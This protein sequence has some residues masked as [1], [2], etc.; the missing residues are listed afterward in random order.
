MGGVI[1]GAVRLA[2]RLRLLC[3]AASLSLLV[4]CGPRLTG[5]Y[6]ADYH[7]LMSR[8]VDAAG[9][10]MNPLLQ[11]LPENTRRSLEQQ[12]KAM[13]DQ[14]ASQL[15]QSMPTRLVFS[16][17]KVVC[18][19]SGMEVT[20]RY[21]VEAD[22]VLIGPVGGPVSYRLTK[23]S[24]GTLAFNGIVFRPIAGT[25]SVDSTA[26]V[27]AWVGGILLLGGSTFACVW[28][29][30]RRTALAATTS[31]PSVRTTNFERSALE[32]LAAGSSVPPSRKGD[33]KIA[34]GS[35]VQSTS[36][37][38]QD[39]SR[40]MPPETEQEQDD[41]VHAP[42]DAVWGYWQRNGGVIGVL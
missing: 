3:F 36:P 29:L 2:G 31:A 25:G 20:S 42:R 12:Q 13:V 16:G 26:T 37:V 22:S 27:A 19:V 6:E 9:Q 28:F 41:P 10:A 5:V 32:R 30:R 14:T 1:T 38:V 18:S 4:G 24:N 15:A 17:R 33:Q 23:R 8:Q 11:G 7:E 40:F 21:T 34:R 35:V 39:D